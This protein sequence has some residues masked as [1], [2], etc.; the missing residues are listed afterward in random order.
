MRKVQAL[1]LRRPPQLRCGAAERIVDAV[2][3][4]MYSLDDPGFC[5]ACG[6]EQNGCEPDMQRGLCEACCAPGVYGADELLWRLKV[7]PRQKAKPAA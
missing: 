2:T 4:R 6:H 5:I 1:P 3:R 7:R